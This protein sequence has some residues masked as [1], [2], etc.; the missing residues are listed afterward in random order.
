MCSMVRPLP[1]GEPM[2]ASSRFL[3]LCLLPSFSLVALALSLSLT[4]C[5]GAV[6]GE[7]PSPAASSTSPAVP[8]PK[9]APTSSASASTTS[10]PPRPTPPNPPTPAT[11]PWSTTAGG[12]ADFE[13]VTINVARTKALVMS[14]SRAALGL[15]HVGATAS[16]AL[17]SPPAGVSVKLFEYA[18]APTTEQFCTDVFAPPTV[19]PTT[20]YPTAGSATF[21]LT[22]VGREGEFM[23]SVEI[24]GARL[25]SS[26][27][28]TQSVPDRSFSQV[29]LGWSPG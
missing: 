14:G 6:T 8:S 12:C 22:G 17:A 11:D 1:N 9:G 29:S 15:D 2:T 24:H 18:T 20:Y 16:V 5:G 27:G 4:G 21:T 7:E 19:P 28:L 3:G 25:R 10:S 26:T 13:I 23:L